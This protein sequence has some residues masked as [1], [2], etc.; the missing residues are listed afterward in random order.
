MGCGSSSAAVGAGSVVHTIYTGVDKTTRSAQQQGVQLAP[1]ARTENSTTPTEETLAEDTSCPSADDH[2]LVKLRIEHP[3]Q[4]M[5][6]ADSLTVLMHCMQ[7]G[8]MQAQRARGKDLLLLLGNTGAGQYTDDVEGSLW[9]DLIPSACAKACV[10]LRVVLCHRLG[11]STFANYLAG[12]T[13]VGVDPE[14]LGLLSTSDHIVLVQPPEE[15]GIRAPM[16]SI[17]HTNM[18]HTFLPHIATPDPAAG[19]K[20]TFCQQTHIVLLG[21]R[22]NEHS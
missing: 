20:L 5:S 16:M 14:S 17:G 4:S 15:G 3:K 1:P 7:Q 11:K 21:V 12:C 22:H 13:M 2:P 19:I 18:S 9:F 10:A 6:P 8:K